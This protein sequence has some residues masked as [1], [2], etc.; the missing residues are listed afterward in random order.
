MSMLVV[1]RFL[2]AVGNEHIRHEASDQRLDASCQRSRLVRD[3]AFRKPGDDHVAPN[4]SG[5]G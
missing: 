4:S 1:V 5:R 3:E 2:S